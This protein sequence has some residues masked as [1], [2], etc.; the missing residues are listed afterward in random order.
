M[1]DKQAVVNKLVGTKSYYIDFDCWI[2]DAGSKDEA[3]DIVQE[4]IKQ[5]ECPDVV[6]VVEGEN[7][8]RY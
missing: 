7:S 8:D 1:T 6:D 4:R 2:V 5:G 3:W